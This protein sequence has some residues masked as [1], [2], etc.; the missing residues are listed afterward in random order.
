M[1]KFLGILTPQQRAAAEQA[2][3]TFKDLIRKRLGA[4]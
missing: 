4:G 3:L 2:R 1:A